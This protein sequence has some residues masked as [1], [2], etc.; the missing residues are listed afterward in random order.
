MFYN[1]H[2]EAGLMDVLMD[3]TKNRTSVYLPISFVNKCLSQISLEFFSPIILLTQ[4]VAMAGKDLIMYVTKGPIVVIE[5]F[6]FSLEDNETNQKS[7]ELIS[8]KVAQ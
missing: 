7:W 6:G 8:L 3:S 1:Y 4:R 2:S 5:L